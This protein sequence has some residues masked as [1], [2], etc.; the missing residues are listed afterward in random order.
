MPQNNITPTKSNYTMLKENLSLAKEGFSL[1]EQKREVLVMNLS[2]LL[3][4]IRTKREELDNSLMEV[5]R[6]LKTLRLELDE[7]T[8]D[9]IVKN[10]PQ[11][12]EADIMMHSVMGVTVPKLFFVDK[13]KN[14]KASLPMG[15][16]GTTPAFDKMLLKIKSIRGLMAEV[17]YLEST[18]WRLVNEIKKTQR[19][20]NSL[21]N[22]VIPETAST[23]KFIKEI[24]EEK[25]RETLFQVKRIKANKVKQALK[26]EKA[27][28]L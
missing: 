1:L 16:S 12:Y 23:M 25:D 22:F 8:L 9:K 4:N 6:S 19:R 24:L 10:V 26:K 28:E 11:D 13:T 7:Q 20:I 27:N 21:D 2:S 17:A 3:N 14:S 5:F 15:I 18:A